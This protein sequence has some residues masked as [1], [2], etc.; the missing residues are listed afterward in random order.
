M[1]GM[2]RRGHV[3]RVAA[4]SSRVPAWQ[5]GATRSRQET[6]GI[7]WRCSPAERR[8]ASAVGGGR[9]LGDARHRRQGEGAARPPATTSSASAPASRTSRRRRRSSRRPPRRAMTREPPLHPDGR[10]R[11]SCARRSRAKTPRLGLRGHGLAGARHERRQAGGL[12]GVRDAARPRRRGAGAG[13]LLDDLPRGRRPR[14]RRPGRRHDDRAT[15]FHVTVDR[16]RRPARRPPR[17]C[18]SSRP[19]TRPAR[20]APP[21]EVAAVGSWAADSR[22]VG[23]HRRDLR[24]PRLR[25]QRA[26][27][28]AG[29]RCPSSPTAAS[30]STAWPRPTP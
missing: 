17:C 27:L 8:V 24:A 6:G 30:W 16:S 1:S 10:P 21:S 9:P 7:H 28:D 15:G 20:F 18:S 25:R 23:A 13:A 19:T 2:A 29:G 22:P 11:P 5:Y 3:R 26:A 4:G 12:R 14:R